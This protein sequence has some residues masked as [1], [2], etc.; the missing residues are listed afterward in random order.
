MVVRYKE[1]NVGRSE[2]F[3]LAVGGLK[4]SERK[5]QETTGNCEPISGTLI[6]LGSDQAS[7]ESN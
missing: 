5:G 1:R 2:R 7:A 3:S 4:K 6:E